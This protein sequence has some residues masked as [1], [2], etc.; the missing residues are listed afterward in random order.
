MNYNINNIELMPSTF[1]DNNSLL[2]SDLID[3]AMLPAQRLC[4]KTFLNKIIGF[5]RN[6]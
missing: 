2:P 4:G 1:A 5:P 6:Q 3:F